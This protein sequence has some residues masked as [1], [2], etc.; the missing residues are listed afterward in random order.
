MGMA[1]ATGSIAIPFWEG[2]FGTPT[3]GNLHGQQNRRVAARGVRIDMK[4]QGDHFALAA[5]CAVAE[6]FVMEFG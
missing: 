5:C 4:T 6:G 2:V 1:V 3:P